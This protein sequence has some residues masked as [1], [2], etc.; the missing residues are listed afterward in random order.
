[1]DFFIKYLLSILIFFPIVSILLLLL[2]NKKNEGLLRNLSTFLSLVEFIFSVYL[3]IYFKPDV[4]KFQFVEKYNWIPSFGSSYYLGIDGVSLFLILLTT[5]L[6][7]ISL[8]SSYKYIKEHVKEFVILMLLMETFM[9]GTFAALDVLLFYLFWEFMLIPMYFI[10]GMWG[11]GKRVYSAVKFVLYTL[12]GS[13][14]MLFGLIYI[15]IMHYDQ[16]GNFTFNIL[17]LYNTHIP[18]G[19]QIILFIALFLG[20]AIK[21]PLFPFHTWLPDAHTEAPTA[22]SVILAGVLLK[23]GVYG[24]FRF[25]IPLLPEAAFTLAPFVII[26]GVT[27]ILYGA[28]VSIVQKDLKRLVAYSS[29]SHMG[30]I[31]LGLFAMSVISVN[32]AILQLLNH[33][34]ATGA[35]F[36]FV[37]MLYERM[38]TR[39]IKDFGGIA[40]KAPILTTLFLISVLASV[41]LP[42]LNGFVGEFLILIG[43]FRY[44]PALTVI[45]TSGIIFAAV[46]LLWMFQRVMFQDITNPAAE[47]FEDMNLREIITVLPLI[48]LMFFIG[49]YPAPFLDRIGPTVLHFV[50]MME[51]HKTLYNIIKLKTGLSNV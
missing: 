51:H 6:T 48:F 2:I 27:G 50:T 33:G 38:H 16:T 32:G 5:L 34:I 22:G 7:F 26:L 36:L 4:Y 43:S 25:A 41:G 49:F 18:I 40:K 10:I 47:N 3:F 17:K 20:F 13:L 37:G 44:Y 9:V 39:Q 14:I 29:V 45:A 11:T 42:G 12:S 30:F 1:M 23:F 8:L 21:V 15:F 35:L 19:T 24:F 28:F 31:M 46:Y